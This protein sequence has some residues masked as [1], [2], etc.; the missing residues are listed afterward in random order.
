M[1]K[2]LKIIGIN[3]T[4]AQEVR[5]FRA[6]QMAKPFIQLN[7]KIKELEQRIIILE[8]KFNNKKQK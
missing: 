2:I 7:N 6:K 1:K 3:W 4:T 5:E 8:N